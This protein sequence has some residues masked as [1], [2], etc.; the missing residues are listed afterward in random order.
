MRFVLWFVLAAV[1]IIVG[2][3]YMLWLYQRMFFGETNPA[4]SGLRD[5]DMR[6]LFTLIPLVVLVFWKMPTTTRE[7][8]VSRTME[9]LRRV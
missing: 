2:A 3:G 4:L 1:G 9:W 5:M 7:R 6:E 8:M